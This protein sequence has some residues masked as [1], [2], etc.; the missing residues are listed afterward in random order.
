MQCS[1]SSSQ[2]HVSP[3]ATLPLKV[4]V[5][6]ACG[7]VAMPF[8]LIVAITLEGVK[9]H[10]ELLLPTHPAG[11]SNSQPCATEPR[12]WAHEPQR[13]TALYMRNFRKHRDLDQRSTWRES[14]HASSGMLLHARDS[15]R[16]FFA[17]FQVSFVSSVWLL[18]TVAASALLSGI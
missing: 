10:G 4:L 3:H 5:L 14:A 11:D 9:L 17:C 18:A 2:G 1:P 13:R 8:L 7:I 6:V 16:L 15:P 12:M